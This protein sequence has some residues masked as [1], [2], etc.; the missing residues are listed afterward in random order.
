MGKELNSQLVP[1][2]LTTG[3]LS[4][5]LFILEGILVHFTH[6]LEPP[7]IHYLHVGHDFMVKSGHFALNI[8][9][10]HSMIIY[11]ILYL[12]CPI[13]YNISKYILLSINSF[14]SRQL[15]GGIY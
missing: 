13:I 4:D 9:W 5:Y 6:L 10:I 7:G 12:E 14:L 3:T 15:A 1:E 11:E 2:A 8:K